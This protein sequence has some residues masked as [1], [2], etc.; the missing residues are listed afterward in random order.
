MEIVIFSF[1]LLSFS[2]NSRLVTRLFPSI[3]KW[4]YY[5]YF[6]AFIPGLYKSSFCFVFFLNKNY[7]LMIVLKKKRKKK[8]YKLDTD[9]NGSG[10]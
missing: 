2:V 5:A 7:S 4:F 3:L 10:F 9:V 6:H 8:R 1:Q